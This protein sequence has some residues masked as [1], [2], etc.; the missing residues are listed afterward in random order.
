MYYRHM[1]PTLRRIRL[2]FALVLGVA[3]LLVHSP[4][5]AGEGDDPA[6]QGEGQPDDAYIDTDPSALADFRPALDDHGTWADD[7]SYGTVWVPNGAEV[8][9]DFAPYVTGGHWTYENDYVWASDYSW[10]WV[11]FHYGRW[12][13]SPVRGWVWI[14]G[15]TYAGAWVVWRVG[16]DGSEYLGWA[17]MAPAWIWINGMPVATVAPT[18]APYVYCRGEDVFAPAV[19]TRVVRGEAVAPIA[20]Q[21]HPYVRANPSVHPVVQ[22]VMHGPSLALLGLDPTRVPRVVDVRVRRAQAFARASTA[23]AVG[24]RAP[25]LRQPLILPPRS[26]GPARPMMAPHAARAHR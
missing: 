11:A 16:A 22:P 7:E 3:P 24:A 9:T 14:P 19:A 12:V 13:V 25:V 20:A 5:H 1:G 6:L 8:G 2:A 23:I 4:A 17:P 26:L 10:G 15:R 18:P 21:T